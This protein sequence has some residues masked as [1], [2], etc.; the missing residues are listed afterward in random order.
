MNGIEEEV[1][2]ERRAQ[3]PQQVIRAI[4]R[5]Q[6]EEQVA[7]QI[8]IVSSSNNSPKAARRPR[9]TSHGHR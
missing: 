9:R 4:P 1:A 6:D 7:P 5:Q 8:T 2:G 3:A